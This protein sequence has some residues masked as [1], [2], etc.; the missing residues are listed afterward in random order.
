MLDLFEVKVTVV[1]GFAVEKQVFKTLKL[2]IVHNTTMV[3]INPSRSYQSDLQ[4]F[5]E[6]CSVMRASAVQILIMAS[7]IIRCSFIK[8]STCYWQ[9]VLSVDNTYYQ[10]RSTLY[11]WTPSHGDSLNDMETTFYDME[12]PSMT[13]RLPLWHGGCQTDWHLL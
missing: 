8:I 9:W 6:I 5:T 7:I 11:F 12:T 1:K 2:H 13:W 4:G 3:T 10:G